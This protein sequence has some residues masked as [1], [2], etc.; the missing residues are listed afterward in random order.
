CDHVLKRSGKEILARLATDHERR[1]AYPAEVHPQIGTEK[2]AGH[3]PKVRKKTRRRRPKIF[4]PLGFR[5]DPGRSHRSRTGR[6]KASRR[7]A[8]EGGGI[9]GEVVTVQSSKCK[10]QR[11]GPSEKAQLFTCYLQL[12]TT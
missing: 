3:R 2:H 12:G 6:A 4:K 11:K 8:I 1:P 9:T 5:K 7:R 10:V